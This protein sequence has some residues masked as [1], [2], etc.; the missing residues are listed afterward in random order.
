M[1]SSRDSHI[2]ELWLQRPLVSQF[3]APKERETGKPHGRR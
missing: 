1:S 2:I 3:S